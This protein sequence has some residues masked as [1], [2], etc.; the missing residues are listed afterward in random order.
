MHRAPNE[1]WS[2]DITKLKGPQKW[3]YYYL[4]VI[5]DIFSRYVVGWMVAHRELAALARKLIEETMQETID[6]AG[7][8]FDPCRQ[9]IEHDLEA[10]CSSSL[11]IWELPKAIHD[12][13]SVMTIPILNLSSKP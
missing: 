11:P 10:G 12:P 4:Y 3:T 8:A 1:V 7:T 6:P 13:R 5:L 2:W 9:R